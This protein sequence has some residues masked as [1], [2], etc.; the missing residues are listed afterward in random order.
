MLQRMKRVGTTDR[1]LGKERKTW[2][3]R[4]PNKSIV[5]SPLCHS[6]KPVSMLWGRF[7]LFIQGADERFMWLA[8]AGAIL[9][10]HVIGM[11]FNLSCLPDDTV[12]MSGFS[13]EDAGVMELYE[14]SQVDV[15]LH[16]SW[17]VKMIKLDM[18]M[19][20]LQLGAYQ[21]AYILNQTTFTGD[22]VYSQCPQSWS[23]PSPAKGS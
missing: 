6:G 13:G 10:V 12:H 8:Y 1:K 19:V 17:L 5:P 18:L 14:V 9:S 15:M 11:E 22:A 7:P 23:H 2:D 4:V 21:T 20:L 16:C 3:W